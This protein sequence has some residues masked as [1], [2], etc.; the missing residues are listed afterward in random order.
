M[1]GGIK[2]TAGKN[3]VIPI[4]EKIF[5]FISEMYNPEN[6]Y[7]IPENGQPLHQTKFRQRYW[8]KSEVLKSLPTK[9]LPHDG[10]HTC[11]T[12]MDD[13]EIPLKIRQMILGHTSHDITTGTYTHK[14]IQQLID[15]INR[16]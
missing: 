13:A 5:P 15:A 11:A 6:E 12:L 3:R 1:R 4:A 9:H 16:I 10:R 2:T 7:L 14:T 8:D